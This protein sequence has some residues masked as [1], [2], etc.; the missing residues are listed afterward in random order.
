[1]STFLL[2]F[3]AQFAALV[4]AGTKPHT[5]RAHRRDG[6]E[7][8]PGDMLHLYTGLRSKSARLLR[9]EPCQY[10]TELTIQPSAGNVHHILLGGHPLD[11]R[12][13]EALAVA[14]G[15]PAAAEFVQFFADTYGLPFTGLLIGWE[16]AP[17]YVTRH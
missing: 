5:V 17:V 4:E 3:R 15:F 16:P 10:T 7:P 12:Q 6:R 1:M 2:N 11:Q 9:R 13:I 8:L 14:D